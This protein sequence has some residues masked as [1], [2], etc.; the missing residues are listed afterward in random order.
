MNKIEWNTSQITSE[1][2]SAENLG[3]LLRQIEARLTSEGQVVCRFHVNGLSLNE[4]DEEKFAGM[5]LQ[6]ISVL[7]VESEQPSELLLGVLKNWISELPEVIAQ[8]DKLAQE[9]K[10]KGVEGHLKSFVDLIDTTQFLIDSILSLQGVINYPEFKSK[11]WVENEM[12]TAQAT[13]DALR[14]FES[15]DFVLLAEILEY[16]LGH[17]LQTWQDLLTSMQTKM[18]ED[19]EQSQREF[20]DRI[21]RKTT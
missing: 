14:A 16:D 4:A 1:F 17:A 12:L 11:G 2:S 8:A 20:N 18:K 9:I 5:P 7:Q 6:E 21:F 19:N 10:F 3:Q 13:G 15:K